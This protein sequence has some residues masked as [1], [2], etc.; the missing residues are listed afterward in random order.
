MI[1]WADEMLWLSMPDELKLRNTQWEIVGVTLIIFNM[2][3]VPYSRMKPSRSPVLSTGVLLPSLAMRSCE[4]S[5]WSPATPI[6]PLMM[7]GFSAQLRWKSRLSAAIES[8]RKPAE[9][10]A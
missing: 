5:L 7:V 4:S 3:P 9:M 6:S 8:R 2:P 10:T 1:L